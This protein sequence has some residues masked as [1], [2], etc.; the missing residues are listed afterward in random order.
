[1]NKV[2][3]IKYSISELSRLSGIKPHTIRVWEQRYGLL[4]PK[5]TDTKIRF[6]TDDD[7]KQLMNISLL[8]RNGVKISKIACLCK[9]GLKDKVNEIETTCC[10]HQIIVDQLAKSMVSFDEQGFEKIINS[11]ILKHG[12]KEVMLEIIYPFLEKIGLLWM[13]GNINPAQEHFISNLIRQKIIV[14]IDGQV[15]EYTAK[16]KKI[17]MYLPQHELHELSLL[18]FAYHLK[19]HHHRIIYLGANV[20]HVDIQ[21]VIDVYEPD[22]ILTVLT[23]S[24]HIKNS[25]QHIST[26]AKNNLGIKIKVA[27]VQS[28]H[29][30]KS[31]L[32]NIQCFKSLKEVMCFDGN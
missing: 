27:G 25:C 3:T 12:F 17:L 16:S 5:R 24:L 26:I 14:A 13:T 2:N 31:P 10:T 6:Y 23:S 9:N 7:L 18:F 32:K 4:K 11:A 21:P 20:P 29:L 8:N 19:I 15:C 28:F 22:Y 30:A 1:V